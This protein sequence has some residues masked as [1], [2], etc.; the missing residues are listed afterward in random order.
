M[1][2]VALNVR[3]RRE[4]LAGAEIL[5]LNRALGFLTRRRVTRAAVWRLAMRTLSRDLSYGR[6]M[7]MRATRQTVF[8]MRR[9]EA[10]S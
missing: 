3:G 1:I 8:E 7:A 2:C 10:L 6:E 5:K 9:T 4:C